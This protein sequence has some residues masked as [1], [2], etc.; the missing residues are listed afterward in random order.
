MR[1][2]ELGLRRYCDGRDWIS[3][4]VIAADILNCFLR[5]QLVFNMSSVRQSM[6]KL[7]V[8]RAAYA[9]CRSTYIPRPHAELSTARAYSTETQ[10]GPLRPCPNCNTPQPLTTSPCASC[11]TLLPISTGLSHHSLLGLSTPIPAPPQLSAPFDLGAELS[12]LPA[13]GYTLDTR[14]L[15]TRML[16]KQT[17][18]H[19]DRYGSSGEKVVALARELSGRIN[20]AYGT[21]ADPL[22]RAE[23]IVSCCHS[24]QQRY[25][26]CADTSSR[27]IIKDQRRR[28]R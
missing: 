9:A 24:P 11:Q 22:K 19:P 5:S 2:S 17:Q 7:A 21:L 4:C 16:K 25:E 27:Y 26:A 23:Y 28:T 10:T 13:H 8:P 18:L 14:D 20:N 12:L 15:R 6:F 3:I 1:S